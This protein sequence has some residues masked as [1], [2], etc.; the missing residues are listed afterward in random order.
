MINRRRA[1]VWKQHS[2]FQVDGICIGARVIWT[3]GNAARP[4]R[5]AA[6]A[7]PVE[8]HDGVI[9]SEA[10]LMVQRI[11]M[12]ADLQLFKVAQTVDS[13]RFILRLCK[14]W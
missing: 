12:P 2:G 14:S 11:Q 6:R 4:G 5:R 10:I 13:A 8:E 3:P 7:W 9:W 1:V